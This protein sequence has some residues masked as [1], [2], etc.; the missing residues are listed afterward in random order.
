MSGERNMQT[1]PMNPVSAPA[2]AE[3]VLSK[4][5]P[6]KYVLVMGGVLSGIGKGTRA[7]V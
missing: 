1:P 2:S 7:A 4:R 5:K 3:S 6:M